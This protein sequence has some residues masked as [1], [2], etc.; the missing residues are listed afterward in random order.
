MTEHKQMIDVPIRNQTILDALNHY[1]WY[2]EN[3]NYVKKV[4]HLNG[5]KDPN[6]TREKYTNE[7]YRD[8]IIGLHEGHDGYPDKI[9]GYPL[10]VDQQSYRRKMTPQEEVDFQRRAGENSERLGHLLFVKNNALTQLYPPGGFISWHN[11]ANAPGYNFIF[12]W[13]ETGEGSFSY[14]DG[15]TGDEVVL[16]DK[17]GWQCKAGY[18]G[19]YGDSWDKLCYHSA[20]TDCWRLTVAYQIDMTDMALDIQKDTIEEIMSDF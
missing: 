10:K 3:A 16:Q 18:F 20:K 12:T 4:L 5:D 13:S 17:P 19:H 11:N 1:L 7:K 6:G 14:V 15:K 2:Y 9:L 8:H